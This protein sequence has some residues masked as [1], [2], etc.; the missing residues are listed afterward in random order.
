[1][2]SMSP[3]LLLAFWQ[4]EANPI[5]TA[6]DCHPIRCT[7]RKWVCISKCAATCD[8]CSSGHS[9]R[10]SPVQSLEAVD[11]SLAWALPALKNEGLRLARFLGKSDTE[12]YFSVTDSPCHH[13]DKV[14]SLNVTHILQDAGSHRLLVIDQRVAPY[15]FAV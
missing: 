5:R 15:T 4:R 13:S 7:S 1:M 3:L 12:R 11:A 2:K 9:F 10:Y 8:L 14:V 6:F